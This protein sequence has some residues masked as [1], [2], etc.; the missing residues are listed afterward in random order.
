MVG[1]A[2]VWAMKCSGET[3]EWSQYNTPLVL[4]NFIRTPMNDAT[5][6]VSC[7]VGKYSSSTGATSSLTCQSCVFPSFQNN[8]A[9]STCSTTTCA[10]NDYLKTTTNVLQVAITHGYTNY[11]DWI[12]VYTLHTGTC[13]DKPVYKFPK[14]P[15]SRY[16]YWLASYTQWAISS[17]PCATSR[18][19]YFWQNPELS[20][21][22]FDGT[23]GNFAKM[24]IS[25]GWSTRTIDMEIYRSEETGGCDDCPA[26]TPLSPAGSTSVDACFNGCDPGQAFDTNGNCQD[27]EAGKYQTSSGYTGDCLD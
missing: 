20:T 11:W 25:G 18:N 12:G 7:G 5:S 1:A 26:E 14:G 21:K 13:G 3:W 22:T 16:L 19:I 10:T 2:R 8:A 4:S 27:C 24:W 23:T 9:A 15:D 6:C 17:T